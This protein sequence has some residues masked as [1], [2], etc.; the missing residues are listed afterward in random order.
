MHLESNHVSYEQQQQLLL[1][2]VLLKYVNALLYATSYND[3]ISDVTV[4]FVVSVLLVLN[5]VKAEST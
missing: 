4:V 3:V 2:L 5:V 1:L